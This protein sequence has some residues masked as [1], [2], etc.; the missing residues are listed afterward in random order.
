MFFGIDNL[1]IGL[2]SPIP[3]SLLSENTLL[4]YFGRVNYSLNNRYLVTVNFRA[5]GFFQV[6]GGEQ[7]GLFPL[8]FIGLDCI[9]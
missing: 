2:I 5:D 6:Q 7:V 1:S 9:R 8:V 3:S 4:S